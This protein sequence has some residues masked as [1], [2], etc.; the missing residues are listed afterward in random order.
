MQ[1][2]HHAGVIQL[3]PQHVALADAAANAAREPAAFLLEA[4]HHGARRAAL[5]EG[6]E[7]QPHRILDLPVRIENHRASRAINQ[8]DRQG[9]FQIAAARLV[10][11]AALQTRLQHV[12]LGLAHGAL[13][14]E[15]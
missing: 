15:Q 4:P 14:P 7:Q 8:A 1:D 11:D 6:L 3:A 2:L 5:A 12:Q 9:Q 10:A 13:Q